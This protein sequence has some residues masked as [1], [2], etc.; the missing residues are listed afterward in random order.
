MSVH[1]SQ[2]K[3]LV[4]PVIPV[5]TVTERAQAVRAVVDEIEA[6]LR[7]SA[8]RGESCVLGLATGGTMPPVYAELVR[9]QRECG[10]DLSVLRSFNLDEYVGLDARDPRSF[11]SYMRRH[12]VEPAGLDA[13]QVC[14]PD[15]SIGRQDP[16]AVAA[17]YE[18]R[19][20]A[21][22]GLQL[23]LLGLGRNGHIGFNEPGSRGDSRTR[24]VQ[25]AADTRQDAA[26]SF[27]G[28]EHVPR[29][30]ITVGIGT[31]LR[32][33]RLRVLAFGASKA[34]AVAATLG[35]PRTEDWPCSFLRDHRDVRLYVDAAALGSARA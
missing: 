24:M 27:E 6:L 7:A 33:E 32:A 2:A 15:G 10:L 22:G 3:S 29:Q 25:L 30:A 1:R 8:Q 13:S 28:L 31:I 5:S 18:E 4:S 20:A 26:A 16:A 21:A 19:I 11:A 35:G 12:L 14:L 34:A 17:A 9:R 23:Q